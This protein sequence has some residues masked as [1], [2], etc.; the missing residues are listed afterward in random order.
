MGALLLKQA[1]RLRD[2][3]DRGQYTYQAPESSIIPRA[4]SLVT[5]AVGG[6]WRC[7]S[8]AFSECECSYLGQGF[9]SA[10]H[11]YLRSAHNALVIPSKKIAVDNS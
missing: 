4:I 9:L 8:D 6:G 3:D 10:L 11:N 2:W 7:T 5:C 1:R